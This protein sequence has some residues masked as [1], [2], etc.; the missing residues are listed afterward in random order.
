MLR[1]FQM[2]MATLAHTRSPL[3]YRS[4]YSRLVSPPL[5]RQGNLDH[6]ERIVQ[7][8]ID[9]V[10]EGSGVC[11]LYAGVGVLGLNCAHKA[12][13]VRCSDVNSFNPRS[14]ER[15]R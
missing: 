8:V 2:T 4:Y 5:F 1:S 7:A 13:F 11:E 15:S 14:F 3:R 6:F 10:P 9:W 12:S